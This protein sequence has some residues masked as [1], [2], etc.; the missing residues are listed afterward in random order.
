MEAAPQ[1]PQAQP[2]QPVATQAAA[3]VLKSP[4]ALPVQT[5]LTPSRQAANQA[6][7]VRA[8]LLDRLVNQ[9][10]EVMI[11]RSRLESELRQLRGVRCVG[12]EVGSR[13][14]LWPP[15]VRAGRDAR[16]Q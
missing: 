11:T 12:V 14:G 2:L 4:I 5:S 16:A 15:P 6:V 13:P 10:G 8:Q 9:A 1:E 3:P 7:R